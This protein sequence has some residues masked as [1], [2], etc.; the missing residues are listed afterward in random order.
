M[1]F[2]QSLIVKIEHRYGAMIASIEPRVERTEA[3]RAF[4]YR[5][6]R[7]FRIPGNKGLAI[8]A[9]NPESFVGEIITENVLIITFLTDDG[10]AGARHRKV[11]TVCEAMNFYNVC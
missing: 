9:I 2:P 7:V 6:V 3:E 1:V 10:A 11:G 4:L 8:T 5:N